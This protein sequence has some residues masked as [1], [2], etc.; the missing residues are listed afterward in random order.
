MPTRT[1]RLD[2]EAET[3]LSYIRKATG[4]PI[5]EAL[6]QGLHALQDRV[7]REA[8]RTPYDVYRQ[9]DLGPGGWAVG[10]STDAKRAATEAIRRKHRR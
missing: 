7:R 5:S 2:E 6:K 3:A 4:L 1:V 9:L 10:P 8:R